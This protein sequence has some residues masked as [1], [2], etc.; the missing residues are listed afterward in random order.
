ML[1][2]RIILVFA[3]ASTTCFAQSPGVSPEPTVAELQLQVA[4]KDVLAASQA[5]Q[6][7][8]L[9]R[10]VQLYEIALGITQQR[11]DD[12]KAV[13]DANAAERK[14]SQKAKIKPP[15]DK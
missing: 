6:I 4:R 11:K 13:Q 3:F 9:Q 7:H 14:A 12:E 15:T 5:A 10:Q 2:K 1:K 8:E